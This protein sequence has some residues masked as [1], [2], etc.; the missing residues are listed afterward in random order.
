MKTLIV[1][2][3]FSV[4]LLSTDFSDAQVRVPV[5]KKVVDKTNKEANEATDRAIDK[6]FNQIKG[7][8]GKKKKNKKD[9]NSAQSP[10]TSPNN[11]QSTGDKEASGPSLDWAKYDFVPGDFVIF[12]DD[13]AGEENGK[14][15]SRWDLVRG[16]VEVARVDGENVIMFREGEPSIVP[17]FKDAGADHLPDVFTVEFDLSYHY[18][19]NGSFTVY[20]FDKKNQKSGSPTGYT[21]LLL[22]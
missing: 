20:L 21:Y 6:G 15:P 9:E 5:K 8:F 13:L 19:G 17:Y 1:L 12:E 3:A 10:D 14:F 22:C 18:L 16:V 4:S 7:L 2:L 11:Q